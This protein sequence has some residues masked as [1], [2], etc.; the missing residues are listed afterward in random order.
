MIKGNLALLKSMEL[1]WARIASIPTWCSLLGYRSNAQVEGIF[2]NPRKMH[3]VLLR[4]G[5]VT[6]QSFTNFFFP[7]R[8]KV[9]LF[10]VLNPSSVCCF[11]EKNLLLKKK[12]TV[13]DFYECRQIQVT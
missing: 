4:A 3:S 9:F 13:Q 6:D 11:G 2:F 5:F 8:T 7:S 12:K 1:Q 10:K